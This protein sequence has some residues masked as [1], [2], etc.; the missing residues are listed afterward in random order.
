M[1]TDNSEVRAAPVAEA[2]E[3]IGEPQVGGTL[4]GSY[5]YRNVPE[6]PEGQ[7]HYQWVVEG[8]VVNETIAVNV[9]SAYAGKEITFTVTPVAQSGEIGAPVSSVAKIAVTGFQNITDEENEAC[10]MKQH[11]NFSFYVPEPPDRIFVSTGGAFSL[12]DAPTKSVH[13]RGQVDYGAVVPDAIKSYLANNPATVLYSTERDFG[14]L[15]PV[16]ASFRNQLLLWGGNIPANLDLAKLRNI[17]SV[18]ANGTAFAYIYN[19]MNADN[20]WIGAIGNAANGGV[21]PD[22][23]HLKLVTDPPHAIYSTFEAFAVLTRSG[24]VYAWGNAASGGL[25]NADA[26]AYLD[27]IKVK[28]IIA[29]MSAFCAIDDADYQIVPWGNAANGG[30]IPADRLDTI[31][32]ENGVKNII[33]NRAAFCAITKGRSMAVSWGN[34]AQGGDMGPGAAGLAA[35]GGIVLCR[36]ATWAFCMV[37]A[38]GQAE[39]WGVAN[40]GGTI[41]ATKANEHDPQVIENNQVQ[42]ARVE[43]LLGRS[44]KDS[45]ETYFK[46]KLGFNFAKGQEAAADEWAVNFASGVKSVSSRIVIGDGLVTA[47][48]NDSSFFLM[49][50]DEDLFTNQLWVWGQA[51]GG[52][53]MSADIRQ[54]LMASQI[55][56]VYCTNGAYGLIV[57]Q[58]NTH[59]VVLVWGAT[60]AQE[61]AGEIP[62]VPPEVGEMLRGGGVIEMYSIKRAPPVNPTPVRVDP[63]FAARHISGAYVLWG[64]NVDNHVFHPSE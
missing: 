8:R 50:Q 31:L 29:N 46:S 55:R 58:G 62:A 10:F 53:A 40:S 11:G 7:S 1:K 12:I 39:A 25:I 54:A 41:P 27:R 16:A 4:N 5:R 51:N 19:Q 48:G 3:I 43:D 21:V 26:Q 42:P 14:A 56:A 45:I 20:H 36:V 13:V 37:N 34:A 49:A 47:F 18:Y 33:A 44:V 63:S 38:L 60:L 23:I 6:N 17:N 59:G 22:S 61:D 30:T 24:K 2:V 28:R 52:G 64:G 9:I 35:R 15:V 57:S 32:R